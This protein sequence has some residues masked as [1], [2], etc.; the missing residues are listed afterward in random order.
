MPKLVAWRE[1]VA[2]DVSWWGRRG[3]SRQPPAAAS[4]VTQSRVIQKLID[5]PEKKSHLDRR[6]PESN[7]LVMIFS[8]DQLRSDNTQNG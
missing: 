4:H 5:K 3:G 7:F 6:S 8:Q 2:I 1:L